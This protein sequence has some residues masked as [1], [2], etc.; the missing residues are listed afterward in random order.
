MII[1]L[2]DRV[3]G[4]CVDD[5]ADRSV[6]ASASCVLIFVASVIALAAVAVESTFSNR[7]CSIDADAGGEVAAT[8]KFES[9][10][11]QNGQ[12]L[13]SPR[14]RTVTFFNASLVIE[15]VQLGG[16]ITV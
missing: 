9:K 3:Q 16:K 2:L 11:L 13:K 5:D 8:L 12:P 6:I 1:A 4:C 10:A 15:D 14:M 7:E